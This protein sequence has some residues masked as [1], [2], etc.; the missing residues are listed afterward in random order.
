MKNPGPR[1]RDDD[2]ANPTRNLLED[3][4]GGVE[5]V[6]ENVHVF[7]FATGRDD[8]VTVDNILIHLTPPSLEV[9]RGSR[10]RSAS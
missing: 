10:L 5:V 4:R 7:V 8:H 9:V 6:G 2:I 1:T 3:L